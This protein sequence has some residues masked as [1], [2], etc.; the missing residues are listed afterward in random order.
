MASTVTPTRWSRRLS[1]WETGMWLLAMWVF[2]GIITLGLLSFNL[3]TVQQGSAIFPYMMAGVGYPGLLLV[4][5]FFVWRFLG[6]L[7][8][9]NRVSLPSAL[10]VASPVSAA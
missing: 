1:G 5:L 2:G 3:A 6:S 7:E 4:T 9:R 8:A 10:A